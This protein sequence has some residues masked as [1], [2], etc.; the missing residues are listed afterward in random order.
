[1]KFNQQ[2]QIA[3]FVFPASTMW[4]TRTAKYR[5]TVTDDR[6]S[7]VTVELIEDGVTIHSRSINESEYNQ[8]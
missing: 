4:S 8:G 5:E 6:V 3:N 2:N 7:D 1:M